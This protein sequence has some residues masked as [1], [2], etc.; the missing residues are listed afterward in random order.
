MNELLLYLL[1]SSICVGVLYL[2]FR[3][4]LRKEAFFKM[5]R[6]VLLAIVLCSLV[7]PKLIMPQF[8][9]QSIQQPFE[10]QLPVFKEE[11]NNLLKIPVTDNS[12]LKAQKIRSSYFSI[13][14]M[15]VY[16][17]LTGLVITFLILVYGLISI[18]ILY[19]EAKVIRKDG[20]TVLIVKK[21]IAAFS[22]GQLVFI[23]QRDYEDHQLVIL[24]HEKEHIRFGHFYDLFFL[25]VIK[26]IFWFNPF[27]YWLIRDMKDIHE[28]Q[29]DD[30]TLSKGID[31]TQY[32]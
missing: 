32:Q 8:I 25:E 6:I 3:I 28:F 26:I 11:V 17:Y 7:I 13:Q 22:F 5:N 14:E 18:F 1:N 16:S 23:S 12:V 31:V 29:A 21:Q 19:R 10:F 2:L 27:I 9:Q 30:H 20:Y 24:A 15:L 4:L